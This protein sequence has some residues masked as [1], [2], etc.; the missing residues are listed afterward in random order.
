MEQTPSPKADKISRYQVE[1]NRWLNVLQ[2]YHT[3]R[4]DKNYRQFT[5]YTLTQ[6]TH[7]KIS[8][9][10]APELVERV[11]QKLFARDPRFMVLARGK[12]LPPEIRDII[13]A[14]CQFFW[15]NPKMIQS[16]GSNRQKLKVGARDFCVI[17]QVAVETFFNAEADSPDFRVWAVEDVI[18]NPA[19]TLKTSNR[20]YF[21]Q[22][23]S[24]DYLEALAEQKDPDGKVQRG[25]FKADA[26]ARVK[27]R[28]NKEEGSAMKS[29][30]TPNQITRSGSG[31]L[32]THVE[33]ILMV[34]V[35][36][37]KT[38]KMCRIVDWCEIVQEDVDP[39]EIEMLPFDFAMDI[40]VPKQPYAFSLL[41]F[42]SGVTSAK[43]LF[44]NQVVDYGSRALNPPL[45]V[46]PAAPAVKMQTLRNAFKV[47]G[48]VFAAPDTA[49][50]AVY[51]PL[52]ST[53]FEL[54]TYLQQR[55]E[56]VSGVSP[57]LGGVP[58]A[59]NDK[60]QGTKGGTLALIEQSV[61]PVQDRQQNIEESII[62]P[63]MTKWIKI[64]GALM[65]KNEEK[66]VLI[67]GQDPKWIQLTKNLLLGD[68][69]L[70]DL[71]ACELISNEPVPDPTTGQPLLDPM[72]GKP[73]LSPL[74]GY[75]I[76]SESDQLAMLMISEGKD[77]RK[78]I[79]Y[80]VDWIIKV[81]TGSMAEQN[82][83]A[84]V[85]NFE[86]YANFRMQYQIPTDL[87]KVSNEMALRMGIKNPE[88][89]DMAPGQMPQIPG[90]PGMTPPQNPAGVPQQPQLAAVVS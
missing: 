57:Y 28:Y 76:G 18:F 88:Q 20:Y 23:V 42:I 2:D 1:Y 17:G 6:G 68:I 34:T 44:L 83:E 84:D 51:P 9:P 33:D 37:R 62:E 85:S 73:A 49:K 21:R 45:F 82:A 66:F 89:Y 80:D 69:T 86:R 55:A 72:T 43:D 58:N 7:A 50:H 3:Q 59:A 27:M 41:D 26:V 47:G 35:Y 5:A 14:A 54:L 75:V 64:A 39:L 36:D 46:D 22:Y 90:M 71:I 60:T 53:G 61:S 48:I 10:V 74:T 40:E 15:T 30:P 87:K 77:P 78:E 79:I 19:M 70:E 12:N 11:I 38:L 67:S 29:D 65:S 81:E 16:T 25:I 8:D 52:P 32:T 31:S 63:M 13:A 4:F 56:G 24:L